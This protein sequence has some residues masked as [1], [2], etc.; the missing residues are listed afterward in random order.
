MKIALAGAGAFGEKHLDGLKNIAG[1]EVVSLVGRQ[2]ESTRAVAEKYGVAHATTDLAES[3]AR[4]DVDAVILCTPTQMHAAQA[5]QCMD[6]GKHVQVEIPLADSLA[7]AEA[8]LAKSRETG[9]VCMVGH[10]RRFNPSHQWLHKRIAAGEIAVQQMDVQTYF[11]RRRNINAKGEPR[12][13]TDHLLWHH[14]AH[15]VD[16][17]AY[18]AGPIV[19]AN[20]IEGPI[21]PELGIAMDMSIQ[22]KAE[23]GAICTLSLSFNNDGPLGTFFRYIC[24][25]GTWIARYDDLVTGREEPVDVSTV[26]VSMNGIELQ[27]REFVAAIREGREPNSSVAQVMPCY[28]VLGALEQQLAGA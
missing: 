1:V 9:R 20:A 19:K 11:F 10:T 2:I 21:H 14:A 16:L 3:L 25:N 22:L 24:D 12:S 7:D 23:S 8:V 15:T 26:D 27:D 13:W 4:D 6:A 5:I 17:F 18:Q 28:R